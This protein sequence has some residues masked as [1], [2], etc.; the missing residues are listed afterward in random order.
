M[1][2]FVGVRINGKCIVYRLDPPDCTTL[3]MALHLRQ[4]SPTGLEWGYRGSG[5]AQLALAILF[6]VLS[7]GQAALLLYQRFKH[8]T[9][10]TL[11]RAGWVMD[12]EWVEEW[13]MKQITLDPK[14]AAAFGA[15]G[16]GV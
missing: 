14:V 8:E 4:H 13:I 15:E 11:P 7:D 10:A 5:P 9:V 12:T 2:T 3:N 1:A 16:E 6:D